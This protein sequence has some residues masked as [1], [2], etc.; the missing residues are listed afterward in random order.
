VKRRKR[1]VAANL[2][3]PFLGLLLLSLPAFT[4]TASAGS[5]AVDGSVTFAYYY[6][7]DR[8][9]SG[10]EDAGAQSRLLERYRLNVTGLGPGFSVHTYFSTRHWLKGHRDGESELRLYQVYGR[11]RRGGWGNRYEVNVGRHWIAAGGANGLVDG[12]SASVVQRRFRFD[13]FLGTREPENR[14][15]VRWPDFDR[16]RWWGVSGRV[17]PVPWADLSA[18]YDGTRRDD[19]EDAQIF[20]AGL[21]VRPARGVTVRYQLR[22]DYTRDDWRSR[23]LLASWRPD[24][25]CELWLEGSHRWPEIAYS[26][27]FARFKDLIE[28]DRLEVRGGGRLPLM[29]DLEVGVNGS[30]ID[31]GAASPEATPGDPRFDLREPNTWSNDLRF[32]VTWRGQM[33]GYY[34]SWGYGGDRDG[35]TWALQRALNETVRLNFDG[36]WLDYTYGTGIAVDDNLATLRAGVDADFSDRTWVSAG[37][38]YLDNRVSSSDWRLLLR[39]R[40]GFRAGGAS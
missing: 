36:N 22:Y 40:R 25:Q 18:S 28:H 7:G 11:Y 39:L 2:A 29:E 1:S 26:S 27:F 33:V 31:H 32:H 24:P 9:D 21:D 37:V 38:E 6:L 13:A 19:Q 14:D 34:T 15:E 8:S 30:A 23:T 10:L 5:P 16:S 35:L 12:V 3:R 17:T 4:S 20:F